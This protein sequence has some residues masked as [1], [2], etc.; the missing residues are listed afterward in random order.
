M[1]YLF[2]KYKSFICFCCIG[3]INTAVDFS[4]YISLTRGI[5]FFSENFLLANVIAF[6]F[7]T[8][9]SFLMNRKWT[10]D[11]DDS[12]LMHQEYI[13]FLS[14]N[15]FGL[16]INTALL[17]LLVRM[18]GLNDIIAK[19]ITIIILAFVMYYIH[20]IWTFKGGKVVRDKM[21]QTDKR[22]DG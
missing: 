9:S 19:S 21:L 14:A 3:L 8:T 2:Y 15:T 17:F 6:F 1:V 4:V 22:K 20:K 12:A 11:T 13:R 18:G 10:F 7:G 5:N 16:M